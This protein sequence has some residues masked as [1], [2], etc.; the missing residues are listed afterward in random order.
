M[1]FVYVLTA[2]GAFLSDFFIK[3]FM[4]KNYARKVRHSRCGN[5]IIIEKYYNKGAALNFMAKKPKVMRAIHTAILVAVAVG[6]YFLLRMPGKRVSKLG[7][8]LLLGG[9]C[10]NLYDRYQKG[11]VIDYFRI[12]MGPKF[13]RNIIFNISDFFVFIGAFLAAAGSESL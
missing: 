5:R 3:R 12:N 11:Y 6:Y 13:L 8:S 10:S 4:D 2:A 7:A 1:N 9:G